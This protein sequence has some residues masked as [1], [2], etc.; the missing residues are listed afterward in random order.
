M[1]LLE[2]A[3]RK[4]EYFFKVSWDGILT[5]IESIKNVKWYIERKVM[6][7][8]RYAEK[9]FKQVKHYVRTGKAKADKILSFHQRD[10]ACITKKKEEKEYFFGRRWQVIR[11][12]NNFCF[13]IYNEDLKLNDSITFPL[14]LEIILTKLG[15]IPKCVGADCG[16]WSDENKDVCL[17]ANIET[18]AIQPRGRKRHLIEDIEQ[19]EKIYNH[20]SGIEP[21]IG[22]LKK[23]GLGRSTKKTDKGTLLEGL[24]S[25]I[26][27]NL[28]K[29]IRLM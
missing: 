29:L 4:I 14:A 13:G 1:K 8:C 22:H 26:A 23:N 11:L 10:V 7:I 16:Y 18:I 5:I 20:R 24:K 25:F 9:Y 28:K 2:K 12:D 17:E 15:F 6:K 27:F 19:R 21:V 3:L